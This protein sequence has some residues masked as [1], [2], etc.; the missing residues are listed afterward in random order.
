MDVVVV[1]EDSVELLEVIVDVDWLP[2][3]TTDIVPSLKFV[4]NYQSNTTSVISSS[5]NKVIASINVGFNPDAITFDPNNGY[6]Y[7]ANYG[8]NTVSVINP[9]SN[10]SKRTSTLM[11]KHWLSLL[12]FA[13]HVWER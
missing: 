2:V 11:K 6:F 3:D 4:T 7:V 13:P 9:V 10:R 5:T 12:R 1:L 8:S